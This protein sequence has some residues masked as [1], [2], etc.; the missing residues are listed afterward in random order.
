MTHDNET[1]EIRK[2]GM[3]AHLSSL[4]W[5]PLMFVGLSFPVLNIVGPLIVW[6]YKRKDHEFIDE[7]G[8]ESL[9]FQLSFTLYNFILALIL[10][11]VGVIIGLTLIT[12][13]DQPTDTQTGGTLFGLGLVGLS[14]LLAILLAIAQ[15]ILVIMASLKAKEGDF[16]R[17]PLTIRFLR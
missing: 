15:L 7:Q 14:F 9:N 10:I 5:I 4:V 6:L 13:P 11:V 12:A 2:W 16:Y 1:E 3:W 8:K 17:Y